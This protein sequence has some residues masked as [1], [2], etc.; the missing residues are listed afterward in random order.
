MP[1]CL[2]RQVSV[3]LS[4]PVSFGFAGKVF[5]QE[6]LGRAGF[7]LVFFFARASQTFAPTPCSG[8]KPL[9]SLG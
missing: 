9:G 3:M 8:F 4:W 5:L 6:Q 2:W 1:Y 7:E